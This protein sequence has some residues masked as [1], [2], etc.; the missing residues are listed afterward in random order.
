MLCG[1]EGHLCVVPWLKDL[2]FKENTQYLFQS[3]EGQGLLSEQHSAPG[4]ASRKIS[5]A[6]SSNYDW[7][8]AAHV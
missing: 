6:S 4:E 7:T 5:Y 1:G 2:S 3:S 8:S